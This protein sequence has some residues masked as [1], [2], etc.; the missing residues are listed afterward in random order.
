MPTFPWWWSWDLRFT[1]HVLERLEDR[2]VTTVDV[3]AMLEC[4]IRLEASATSGRFVVYTRHAGRQW[5]VI[6]E[7]ESDT[8]FLAVVTLF[9]VSE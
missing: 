6:V 3:R 1:D 2:G 5:I 9:Q 7:P 8:R 4:A